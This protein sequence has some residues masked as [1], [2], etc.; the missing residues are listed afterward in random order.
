MVELVVELSYELFELFCELVFELS[1][2]GG[3]STV[4]R[5][6]AGPR[7]R[8]PDRAQPISDPLPFSC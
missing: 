1:D 8:V 7:F 4:F 2:A 6:G 3:E 5:R